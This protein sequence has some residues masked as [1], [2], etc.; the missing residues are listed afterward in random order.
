[1]KKKSWKQ[2]LARFNIH[3]KDGREKFL[4]EIASWYEKLYPGRAAYYKMAL[5]NLRAVQTNTD[6]SWTDAK[7]RH[8]YVSMRVPNELYMYVKRWIPDFGDDSADI[9]LLC[10]VWCDLVRTRKD[11]RH[12]TRL[13]TCK[14][15]RRESEP[16]TPSSETEEA[17][18]E[19][20]TEGED[21]VSPGSGPWGPRSKYSRFSDNDSARLRFKPGKDTILAAPAIR[22]PL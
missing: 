1:M 13:Y 21:P 20:G 5:K 7:G 15:F 16:A 3:M 18:D 11:N 19:E 14:E 4:N 6:A 22:T 2:E 17:E 10:R 9:D 12:H 8:A